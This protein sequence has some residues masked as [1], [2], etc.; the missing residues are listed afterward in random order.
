M[1]PE[2]WEFAFTRPRDHSARL[3]EMDASGIEVQVLSLTVPGLESVSSRE[4]AQAYARRVNDFLADK[5]RESGGRFQAFA[6]V[7]LQDTDA[8]IIEFGMRGVLVRGHTEIS[9]DEQPHYLDMSGFSGASR[10]DSSAP[11]HPIDDHAASA[12]FSRR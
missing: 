2:S 8:A 9:N 7:P 4:T 12:G 6:A 3:E 5:T 1:P 11:H 10:A